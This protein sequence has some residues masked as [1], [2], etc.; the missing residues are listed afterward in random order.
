MGGM[1]TKH[2]T[3][4]GEIKLRS[5]FYSKYD[6]KKPNAVESMC[7]TCSNRRKDRQ[8]R[9]TRPI[10]HERKIELRRRKRKVEKLKALRADIIAD[11]CVVCGENEPCCLH[12]HHLD[13]STKEHEISK[14]VAKGREQAFVREIAKGI[15][16]LCANCHMKVHAGIISLPE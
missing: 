9:L 8:R 6:K 11:G 4:C 15:V 3:H 14:L 12:L 1:D 10:E 5:E 13:P 7:K 2:C 16:V